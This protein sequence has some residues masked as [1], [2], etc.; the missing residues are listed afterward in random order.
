MMSDYVRRIIPYE[1]FET[2]ALE[3][4]LDEMAQKGLLLD[5]ISFSI[6]TFKKVDPCNTRFRIDYK[7]NNH[8]QKN[9]TRREL[10]KNMGWD[11][12]AYYHGCIY[13]T[14][15]TNL[16]KLPP[17]SDTGKNSKQMSQ[18]TEL[19]ICIIFIL[20]LFLVSFIF[21]YMEYQPLIYPEIQWKHIIQAG[22]DPSL[23]DVLLIV[24]FF[25][26]VLIR[27]AIELFRRR[28]KTKEHSNRILHTRRRMRQ[29]TFAKII[30]IVIS[31]G[32][33]INSCTGSYS[34]QM[35]EISS[36][37]YKESISFPLL[38]EINAEE[39]QN[40]LSSI[41]N[42]GADSFLMKE[43]SILAPT[44]LMTRQWGPRVETEDGYEE[45]QYSYLVNYYQLYNDVLAKKVAVDIA[46]EYTYENIP[47]STSVHAMYVS[48]EKIQHLL[49]WHDNIVVEVRYD[50]S[51]D[52]RNCINLY[53]AYLMEA[54]TSTH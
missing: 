50:G 22:V 10:I 14:E 49:L 27:S 48:T 19:C 8:L 35:H 26:V 37:E 13:K 39:W 24:I 18:K 38:E 17:I 52:L 5:S 30:G 28:Y 4:W 29:R 41:H 11:F 32:L 23:V 44:I 42:H 20:L 47:T 53:E 16:T 9:R 1:A 31:L 3:G 54:N 6:A 43:S 34:D 45:S 15:D 33:F 51:T 2:D 36:T 21:I 7:Q 12:A 25:T 46:E 40:L